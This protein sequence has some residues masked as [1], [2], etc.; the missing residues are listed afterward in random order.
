MVI[1][2]LPRLYAILDASDC[3]A[4]LDFAAELFAG[5]VRLLQLRDKRD[6]PRRTLSLA[7][8]IKRFAPAEAMLI[9]NDRPDLCLEAG[10]HG[11]HVG[12][13]D[14][15]VAGTRRICP[16]PLIV[17]TST[18]NRE[19]LVAADATDVDHIAFG[20]IFSTVSKA[21]PD[22]VT[23]LDALRQLRSLT[24]KP[25]VAIGGVTLENCRRVI[26]AGADSVAVISALSDE[27]RLKAAEF[28]RLLS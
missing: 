18:H 14:I 23:G 3:E 24:R 15:S 9:M 16:R 21:N 19:Q 20:P 4:P 11:T 7:R 6:Q 27:P 13:D 12:Q 2:T 26:E 17:G 25:L 5:G 10:F 8:E 28:I 22:P 1:M